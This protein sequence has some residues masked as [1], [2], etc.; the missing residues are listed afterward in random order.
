MGDGAVAIS[1]AIEAVYKDTV[2]RCMCWYHVQSNVK[3]KM[4]E[5]NTNS[6]LQLQI[7][8]DL[9]YIQLSSTS[10]A[11]FNHFDLMEKKYASNPEGKAV[12]DYIRE[13]WI[14]SKLNGWYEGF[15][16]RLPSTN[17]GLEGNN[18]RL[19]KFT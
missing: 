11:F 3:K 1:S 18:R 17:N 14:D 16:P 12:M 9:Q 7:L 5:L 6:E 4:K 13:S 15:A 10:P 19:K 8:R 2:L